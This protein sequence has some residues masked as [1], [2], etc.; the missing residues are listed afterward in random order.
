M[1]G[2]WVY[3]WTGGLVPPVRAFVAEAL[4]LL[5]F[6][7]GMRLMPLAGIH[8][9]EHKVVHAIERGEDLTPETV[10]RMPRIH[11]RCGTNIAVGATLFLGLGTTSWIASQELRLLF[12]AMATLMLWRP[13]GAVVQKYITTRPPTDR[14]IDMGIRSGKELLANYAKAR[15]SVPSFGERLINSGLF[16][17]I[18]GSLLAFLLLAG[19][20]ALFGLGLPIEV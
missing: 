6:F 12:A 4:P 9:A 5:V 8:A 18:A 17:V 1:I 11:P 2:P 19:L 13:L 14:H 3:A 15:T 20:N 10:R 7:G 16:H